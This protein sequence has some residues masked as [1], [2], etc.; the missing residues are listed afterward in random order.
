MSTKIPDR[1]STSRSA[2]TSCTARR[3]TLSPNSQND[4]SKRQAVLASQHIFSTDNNAYINGRRHSTVVTSTDIVPQIPEQNSPRTSEPKSSEEST[5]KSSARQSGST[6]FQSFSL[7]FDVSINIRSLQPTDGR[8]AIDPCYISPPCWPRYVLVFFPIILY[9]RFSRTKEFK[10]RGRCSSSSVLPYVLT[11]I[12][13]L[14]RVY[15]MFRQTARKLPKQWHP[16]SVAY[17]SI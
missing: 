6:A 2:D 7:V 13:F 9:S 14:L 3:R 8:T 12:E 4:A 5:P 10:A 17:R 11:K 16:S 1:S 15:R